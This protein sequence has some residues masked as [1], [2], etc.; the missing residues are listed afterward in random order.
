MFSEL[1]C[2]FGLL[3]V[4]HQAEHVCPRQHGFSSCSPLPLRTTQ[5]SLE[6]ELPLLDRSGH[7]HIGLQ[8][9]RSSSDY[10]SNSVSAEGLG[11]G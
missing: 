4:V 7:P 9:Q 2:V 5:A 6:T 10:S 11:L 3:T 1:L 8:R